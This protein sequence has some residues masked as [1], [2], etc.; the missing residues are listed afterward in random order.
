MPQAITRKSWIGGGTETTPGTVITAPK[1]YIPCKSTMKFKQ[2]E[3]WP[4]EERADLDEQHDRIPTTRH[5]E[6][7]PK[8][9]FYFDSSPLFLRS[10]FGADAATQPDS[11]GAPTAWKHAF[12]LADL[13]YFISLY[14]SYNSLVYSMSYCA[15][16]SW[17]LKYTAEK[18]VIEFD[19]VIKGLFPVKY[20]GAPITP[21][22]STVKAAAGYA[23]TLTLGGSSTTDIS[24]LTI[25]GERKLS[26]WY[27]I[28]GTA[29]FVS[30]DTGGRKVEIDFTARF[31]SDTVFLRYINNQ[32][33]S[34]LIDLL[35]PTIASTTK[36]ELNVSCPVIAYDDGEQ[37]TGKDN[38]L[39]KMKAHARSTA[40]GLISAFVVNTI[41][42]TGY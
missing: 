11:V 17:T 15:T 21:T 7:D 34:L 37:D 13:P 9:K 41:N 36:Y 24:E 39:V 33:D 8:G 10:F 5:G 2:D 1:V 23:P 22:F 14:K 12:T 4:D 19:S 16:E 25:K 6:A 26:P 27:G 3:E 35:G 31:D 28:G 32:D 29:D 30:M 40:S 38:V 18:K 20:T 42:A